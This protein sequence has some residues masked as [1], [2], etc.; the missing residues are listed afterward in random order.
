MGTHPIFESDFDC[1]TEMISRLPLSCLRP[2]L[3]KQSIR[4][5]NS[6]VVASARGR[7]SNISKEEIETRREIRKASKQEESSAEAP[8][9]SGSPKWDST[10]QSIWLSDS[11]P[12]TALLKFKTNP[13]LDAENVLKQSK[14]HYTARTCMVCGMTGLIFSAVNIFIPGVEM[15]MFGLLPVVIAQNIYQPRAIDS[16]MQIASGVY[17]DPTTGITSAI[18]TNT[19]LIGP[20]KVK[21]ID[22]LPLIVVNIPPVLNETGHEAI[23]KEV[24]SL[25]RFAHV[26]DKKE[27]MFDKMTAGVVGKLTKSIVTKFVSGIE[28]NQSNPLGKNPWRGAAMLIVDQEIPIQPISKKNTNGIAAV[29]RVD[30]ENAL[31]DDEWLSTDFM[32]FLKEKYENEKS[33]Q[34]E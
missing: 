23:V 33:I 1:L 29:V 9:S 5:V 18:L 31:K 16:R 24:K 20:N 7:G 17:F 14:L 3:L 8:K 6:T 13:K 4:S 27:T 19:E 22:D 34:K 15:V 30:I 12:E 28:K 21:E 26:F 2:N 10:P 25:E 11:I 32:L